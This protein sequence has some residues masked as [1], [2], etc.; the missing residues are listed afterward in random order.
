MLST[1]RSRVYDALPGISVFYRSCKR[2]FKFSFG[3]IEFNSN[4]KVGTKIVLKVSGSVH[5]AHKVQNGQADISKASFIV[6]IPWH[7]INITRKSEAYKKTNATASTGQV[8]VCVCKQLWMKKI[9]WVDC[10]TTFIWWFFLS[11]KKNDMSRTK[12]L[13]NN[14]KHDLVQTLP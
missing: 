9:V 6:K 7:K 1:T 4:N 8:D 14:L 11:Q 12:C 10:K 2:D 3:G 13:V 5:W